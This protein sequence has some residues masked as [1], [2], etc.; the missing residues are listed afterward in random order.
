LRKALP[1]FGLD[2]LLIEE[3]TPSEGQRM[4]SG[5]RSSGLLGIYLEEKVLKEVLAISANKQ[6]LENIF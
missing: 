3:E 6:V 1:D 5:N 4:V 2:N